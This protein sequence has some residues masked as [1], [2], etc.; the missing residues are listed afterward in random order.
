MLFFMKF[1]RDYHLLLCSSWVVKIIRRNFKHNSSFW[2]VFYS[3]HRCKCDV[4]CLDWGTIR[5]LLFLCVCKLAFKLLYKVDG[6]LL[7]SN[8]NDLMTNDNANDIEHFLIFTKKK[9]YRWK[10]YKWDGRK[11][12]KKENMSNKKALWNS[13]KI[14]I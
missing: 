13:H 6:E 1:C 11:K 2:F 5:N 9:I 4:F 14:L 3:F 12:Q 7:H 8:Q 10:V